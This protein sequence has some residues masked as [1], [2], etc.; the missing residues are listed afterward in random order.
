VIDKWHLIDRHQ[1]IV[2]A[3]KYNLS[4]I[5]TKKSNTISFSESDD[6]DEGY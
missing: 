3:G 1:N 5:N 6:S 2:Q 4:L